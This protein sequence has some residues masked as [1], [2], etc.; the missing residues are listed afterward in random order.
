[1]KKNAH[2]KWGKY[3]C[4]KWERICSRSRKAPV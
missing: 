2:S 3:S 4:A 1:M